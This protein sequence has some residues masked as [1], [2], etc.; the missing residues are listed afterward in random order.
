MNTVIVIDRDGLETV[1]F[2]REKKKQ[3]LIDAP[4]KG[5]K[6]RV[7]KER[8]EKNGALI[9]LTITFAICA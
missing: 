1:R 5:E 3:R 9:T 6:R 2:E 4:E 7:R 8:D